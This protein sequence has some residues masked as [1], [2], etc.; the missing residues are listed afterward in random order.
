MQT[1][2]DHLYQNPPTVPLHLLMYAISSDYINA[3][4]LFKKKN[5]FLEFNIFCS[6][7]V[8]LNNNLTACCFVSGIF[9]VLLVLFALS[10]LKLI[11]DFELYIVFFSY[12]FTFIF[13][14]ADGLCFVCLQ[15]ER[16][17]AS[18]YGEWIYFLYILPAHK[19]THI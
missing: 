9:C 13:F 14:S 11:Q 8:K 17:T 2:T 12:P 15:H 16:K 3:V 6:V 10:S 19:Y 18:N 4:S 1:H 5:K 7:L